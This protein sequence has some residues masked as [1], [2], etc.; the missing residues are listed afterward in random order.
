MLSSTNT[1]TPTDWN[2]TSGSTYYWRVKVK[3]NSGFDNCWSEW[4]EETK[5]MVDLSSP[6]GKSGIP[7][8]IGADADSSS[9]K[10]TWAVGTVA[11]AESGIG[12]YWLQ[13]STSPDES[14]NYKY[15]GNMG[16]VLE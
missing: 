3:D 10:F 2:L 13:V 8:D 6:T 12:G 16:D 7:A 9:I 15:N 14:G 4:S 5:F 11:D 1:W